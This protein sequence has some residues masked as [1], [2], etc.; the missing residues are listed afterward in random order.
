MTILENSIIRMHSYK[1]ISHNPEPK[2]IGVKNGVYQLEFSEKELRK[3]DNFKDINNVLLSYNPNFV[4]EQEQVANLEIEH[5]SASFLKSAKETDLVVFTPH[6]NGYKYIISEKFLECLKELEVSEEDYK[7]RKVHITG[8]EQNYYLLFIP[9]IPTSEIVF[10]KSAIFP[11]EDALIDEVDRRYLS[12]KNYQEFKDYSEEN[13]FYRWAKIALDKHYAKRDII[14]L[15][16][17]SIFF[18][19]RLVQY[20]KFRSITSLV[21]KNGP[22][23]VFD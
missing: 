1:Q 10:S 8:T 2:V 12:F 14:S 20:F 3:N 13:L 5:L 21:I 18:S 4:N 7:I 16:T 22:V 19:D 23:L 11:E 17:G 15:Q 6:F 9:M